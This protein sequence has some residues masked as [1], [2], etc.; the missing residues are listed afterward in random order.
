RGGKCPSVSD[1]N[2]VKGIIERRVNATG[3][4]EPQV[5]TAG[6]DRIVVEVPGVS[7]TAAI[8]KL[9][10][11]T[12]ALYFVPIPSGSA[13]VQ[14]GQVLDLTKYTPLLGRAH[15]KSANPGPGSKGG[16]AG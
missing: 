8:R 3:V 15:L 10:G 12:G 9:V 16:P 2:V 4:S 11:Q 6:S 14:T 13:Q 5:V 7:D 1:V